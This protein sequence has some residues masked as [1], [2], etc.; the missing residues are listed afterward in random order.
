MSLH[1]SYHYKS[2][3]YSNY[4]S[5]VSRTCEQSLL[6]VLLCTDRSKCSCSGDPH[7]TS[8]DGKNLDFYGSCEYLFLRDGCLDGLPVSQETFS[9]TLDLWRF[10]TDKS[11]SWTKDVKIHYQGNVSDM[12]I[13]YTCTT[14]FSLHYHFKK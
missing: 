12:D 8:F 13:K 4:L 5:T 6:F 3:K 2:S 14:N 1:I 11:V 10:G 9:I 7:C